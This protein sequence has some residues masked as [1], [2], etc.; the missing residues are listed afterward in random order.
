MKELRI[1]FHKGIMPQ[2]LSFGLPKDLQEMFQEHLAEIHPERVPYRLLLGVSG[3]ADS[4]ALTRLCHSLLVDNTSCPFLESLAI[5]HFHHHLRGSDADEDESFVRQLA[6]RLGVAYHRGDWDPALRADMPHADRN[7]QA[8]ARRA[9]YAFLREVAESLGVKVIAT[10]HHQDDQVETILF[11]L[12]RGGQTGAW[13]GIRPRRR[14]GDLWL[15][16][17]LLPFSKR[18]LLAYL[19]QIGQ[20]FRH[21]P[22]NDSPKYARNRIRHEEL[23]SLEKETPTFRENLLRHNREAQ[24]HEQEWANALEQ[25]KQAS[26]QGEGIWILPKNSLAALTEEGKFF[27]L[28]ALLK[29]L[30]CDPDGWFPIRRPPLR[31]L[32]QLLDGNQEG[33][34]NLPK[35]IRIEVKAKVVV[36]QNRSAL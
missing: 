26:L 1:V 3:G 30:A 17:P 4:T 28:R 13:C 2:E 14:L 16:R 36:V 9:R 21:D 10:A 23:P 7:L 24:A 27:C 6:E 18:T 5:A 8:A 31:Q 20:T 33:I 34:V 15:I 35:G 25:L 29:E 22:S 32:F 19:A 12:S 11:N